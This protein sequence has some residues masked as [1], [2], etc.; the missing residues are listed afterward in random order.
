MLNQLHTKLRESDMLKRLTSIALALIASSAIISAA[1]AS[2]SIAEPEGP[3][4]LEVQGHLSAAQGAATGAERVIRFDRAG[5]EL[6]PQK[7]LETYTDWT[8]GP[9]AFEGVLLKDL[10]DYVGAIG[11]QIRAVALNDYAVTF[12]ASDADD[13]PVLLALRRNGERMR[14]RDKGPI[15]IIYPND[16]PSER[17]P[18]PHNEKMVWQLRRLEIR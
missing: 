14:I 11:K 7:T 9:Q 13:Y 3:V 18:G 17:T 4:I 16:D 12:P 5:L 10:L 15:W 8:E 2:N 1:H 6:L